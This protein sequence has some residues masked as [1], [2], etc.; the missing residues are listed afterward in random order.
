MFKKLFSTLK[1]ENIPKLF[2]CYVWW[3][4]IRCSDPLSKKMVKVFF[5]LQTVFHFIL[6]W[7]APQWQFDLFWKD[8]FKLHLNLVFI[9][10]LKIGGWAFIIFTLNVNRL[11]FRCHRRHHPTNIFYRFSHKRF[12]LPKLDR[13]ILRLAFFQKWVSKKFFK[14]VGY[15]RLG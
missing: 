12:A 8:W 7:P 2:C 11:I 10:F 15:V 14:R 5:F 1:S 4:V 9:S 13:S 3:S 6:T